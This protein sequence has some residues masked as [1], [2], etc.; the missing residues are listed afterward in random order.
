MSISEQLEQELTFA[1]L[2]LLY[3]SER[4]LLAFTV[5][6]PLGDYLRRAAEGG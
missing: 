3:R 6:P 5:P 1:A 4:G 2:H